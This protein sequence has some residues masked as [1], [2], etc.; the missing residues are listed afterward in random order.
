ML[1]HAPLSGENS[2]SVL[3]TVNLYHIQPIHS[4]S[5][6]WG[7]GGGGGEIP[8]AC[9][10]NVPDVLKDVKKS[11]FGKTIATASTG[12][13]ARMSAKA[14]P[15]VTIEHSNLSRPLSTS[16]SLLMVQETE[17]KTVTFSSPHWGSGYNHVLHACH[18]SHVMSYHDVMYLSHVMMSCTSPTS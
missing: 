14:A 17:G 2:I 12:E 18:T 5:K 11:M 3:G 13:N 9:M 6:F 8:H 4:L 7:G 15:V 10:P 1:N 16:K